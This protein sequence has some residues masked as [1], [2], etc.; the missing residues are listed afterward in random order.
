MDSCCTF[1]RTKFYP[2]NILFLFS[3]FFAF[4]RSKAAQ[5]NGHHALGILAEGIIPIGNAPIINQRAFAEGIC[6][7]NLVHRNIL[8][9]LALPLPLRHDLAQQLI[10]D[11]VM[12]EQML[13]ARGDELGGIKPRRQVEGNAVVNHQKHLPIQIHQLVEAVHFGIKRGNQLLIFIIE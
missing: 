4:F 10:I 3:S 2:K 7:H 8:P 9:K 13:F 1:S 12:I 5:K 6:L 11:A